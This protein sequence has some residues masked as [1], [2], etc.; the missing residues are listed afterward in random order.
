MLGN[1]VGGDLLLEV[2]FCI[3]F[4]KMVLNW[5]VFTRASPAGNCAVSMFKTVPLWVFLIHLQIG[6]FKDTWGLLAIS[7]QKSINHW[8]AFLKMQRNPNS[9]DFLGNG[10][11]YILCFSRLFLLRKS[12]KCI[13]ANKRQKFSCATGWFQGWTLSSVVAR[14]ALPAPLP[15]LST[16]GRMLQRCGVSQ[17]RNTDWPTHR[18]SWNAAGYDRALYMPVAFELQSIRL[19]GFHVL[20]F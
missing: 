19:Q 17:R 9:I 12:F 8:P 10:I 18:Y 6:W 14:E 3:V 5:A 1:S 11:L 2:L 15:L 20:H 7:L 16:L 13:N 4:L